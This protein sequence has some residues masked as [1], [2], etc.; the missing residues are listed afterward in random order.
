[1]IAHLPEL[2][3][4]ESAQGARE[5]QAMCDTCGW[6]GEIRLDR[7][8]AIDDGEAHRDNE[9]YWREKEVAGDGS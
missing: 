6:S 1:M 2:V 8:D 3:E 9:E 7:A 5:Y 4:G